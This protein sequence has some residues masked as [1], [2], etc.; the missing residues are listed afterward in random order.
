M[1]E[2]S[3]AALHGVPEKLDDLPS[4]CLLRGQTGLWIVLPVL[5][6]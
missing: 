4:Q 1:K 5:W 3:E 2:T 6:I